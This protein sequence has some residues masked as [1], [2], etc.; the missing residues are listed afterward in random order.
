MLYPLI[1]CIQ[2][3]YNRAIGSLLFVTG[4]ETKDANFSPFVK[5]PIYFTRYCYG[6]A[7][8]RIGCA[9]E[10][11]EDKDIPANMTIL[12]SHNSFCSYGK[13]MTLEERLKR[14]VTRW[15]L[16]LRC[17][18]PSWPLMDTCIYSGDKW[19][20]LPLHSCQAH[21]LSLRD[22]DMEALQLLSLK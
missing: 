21:V 13:I 20:T 16:K 18:V 5:L 14:E 8:C 1:L 10:P 15:S 4:L 2:F 12:R 22:S 3:A 11:W 17:H 7:E 9:S 19:H 6:M